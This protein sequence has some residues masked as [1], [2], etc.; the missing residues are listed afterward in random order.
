MVNHKF[1]ARSSVRPICVFAANALRKDIGIFN[2]DYI[3]LT[4][5][6]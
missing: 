3:S 1:K 4:D 2:K 5:I 6:L